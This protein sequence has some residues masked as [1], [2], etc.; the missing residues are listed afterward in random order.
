MKTSFD[1]NAERFVDLVVEKIESLTIDWSKP[2]FP[3]PNSA[4]NFLPQNLSG[5]VYSGGNAFLLFFLCEKYNYQCP[6][7]LTFKQAQEE[8]IHILKGAKSF[9]VYYPLFCAYHCDTNER[10]SFDEYKKLTKAEQQEY[11]LSYYNQYYAVFNLDQTN[12]SEIYPDR[13]DALKDKFKISNDTLTSQEGMYENIILDDMLSKQNWVCS[14]NS[15]SS[16]SAYY[17]ISSDNIILPLKSQFKDGQSFY[18]TEL[19]EMAHS[20]GIKKRLNRKGFYD[21]DTVNYGR[22]ELVAELTAALTALYFGIS[23]TIRE[24]NAAYLKG[25]CKRIKEEPKFL[26]TVL[27][28]AIKATKFIADELKV[29]F[30]EE[31]IRQQKTA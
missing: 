29:S 8:G 27:S 9:P 20:T 16:N 26:F 10:I 25:W 28:D 4:Q 19:H 5:R 15:V 1:K 7:F 23:A 30:V 22:E 14:I 24:E 2:W 18:C 21:D 31:E 12:F 11:R 13:W 17:S 3:K 6:I